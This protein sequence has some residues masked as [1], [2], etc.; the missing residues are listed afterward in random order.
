MSQQRGCSRARRWA[1]WSG[2]GQLAAWL[3]AAGPVSAAM[4]VYTV[5]GMVRVRPTD[6]PRSS[7]AARLEAARNEYEP[8]QVVVHAGDS[9]LEEV[10]L[11]ATDLRGPG[12][13]RLSRR[14]LTFYREHY[15]EVTRPSPKSKEGAGWYPDALVPFLN[16]ETGQPLRSGRF[17]G[18]PFAVNP[19]A[20]QPVWIDVFVP[21]ETAPGD[22]S[23]T[24]TVSAR[25]EAVVQVP[26]QLRVWDFTLPDT[27]SM[28][29]N[30][31]EFDDR[32]AAA[33]RVK[34][35]SPAFRVI[36]RRYAEALAAH[37]ICPPIP[38]YLY[39]KVLTDG[40]I[41]PEAT[42]AALKEW[43]DHFHVTGFPINLI[44]REPVGRDR[45]RNVR[46]LR[47]MYA[48]LK[49]NGWARFAY[50]YV[51]DEPND[52][53][54]Y[55]QVRLRAR[56]IHEA[57]PGI[58]VLC[59][60][61]PQPQ[62]PAWGTLVGSVDLWVPLWTLFEEKPAAERLAAGEELWSYTALCQGAKGQD[63]PY[64]EIDF[65][66]LDYRIPAWMNWRYGATGLLYWTT[67]YWQK[68]GDVW[69][70]PATYVPG[71]SCYNGEGSLFYPG[72]DVGYAGPVTSMRLKQIREGLED[73]EYM[74]LLAERG[75]KAVADRL[76]RREA[77]SWTKW[78]EEASH[79]YRAREELARRITSLA[80]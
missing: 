50:V 11:A 77:E 42:H 48:Y 23:G 66:L 53:A 60:E 44:G 35:D 61:Q 21:K 29:A 80:R 78:D 54:A 40:D 39:P 14:H 34:V 19:N 38:G 37:R 79:L 9:A 46:Y 75:Q 30:F 72:A 65:P 13:Q 45:A 17:Q 62:D 28:R 7:P 69:G 49:A 22:Y 58:Q 57:Q 51:L 31:G 3:V 76:V 73:Y 8:F 59:T 27:P 68:A 4:N 26:V 6:P 64:W 36:E 18:A 70:N 55:E 2:L 15:V 47:A 25:N 41:D 1:I 24:V 43:M 5:D 32:I 10:S 74:R 12:G 67:V 20:N 71:R 63:T 56:L 16:P 52:A 33:H